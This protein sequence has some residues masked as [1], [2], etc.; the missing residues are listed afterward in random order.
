MKETIMD[1]KPIGVD[2]YCERWAGSRPKPGMKDYHTGKNYNTQNP[3]KK[4]DNGTLIIIEGPD[5]VGKST[6][7][8]YLMDRINRDYKKQ[9]Q[10][11]KQPEHSTDLGKLLYDAAIRDFSKY[12]LDNITEY[13]LFWLNRNYHWRNIVTPQL[14]TGMT[15]MLDRSWPSTLVYN[16]LIKGV[17]WDLVF[18]MEMEACQYRKPDLM[19]IMYDSTRTDP[20]HVLDKR[21]RE[22]NRLDLYPED[23]KR[24]IRDAYMSFHYLFK[25]CFPC[26]PVDLSVD[27]NKSFEILYEKYVEPYLKKLYPE[28]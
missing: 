17:P 13:G 20:Y 24:E 1:E 21:E 12:K 2:E 3:F 23:I 10:C 15:I 16:S 25:F 6:L 4:T 5:L 28:A 22:I 7:C 26:I 8:K 14:Q 9:A 27:E 18:S 11:Y 19:L